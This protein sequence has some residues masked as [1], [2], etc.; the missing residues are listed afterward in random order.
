VGWIVFWVINLG[1]FLPLILL[2]L[3]KKDDWNGRWLLGIPAV[4][5][6]VIGNLIQFQPY[7][8]DNHKVFLFA[9]LLALPLVIEELMHWIYGHTH[10]HRWSVPV[11]WGSVILVLLSLTLTTFSEVATYLQF[12]ASF[13]AYTSEAR[14]AGNALDAALPRNAIII[15]VMDTVH[16]HPATLTGRTLFMGYAGWI[17]TRGLAYTD[18]TSKI[19]SLGKAKSISEVCVIAAQTGA[20]HLVL[21]PEERTVWGPEAVERLT[22]ILGTAVQSIV[23]GRGLGDLSQACGG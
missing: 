8:W 20:T 23:K 3:T 9:L 21:G 2:S 4:G 17:W 5:L 22:G 7:R 15:G 14:A 11:R 12:R 10:D 6:F 18:R 13:P 19:S 1:L 16:N